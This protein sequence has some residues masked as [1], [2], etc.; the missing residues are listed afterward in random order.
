[1]TIV[2]ALLSV[3]SCFYDGDQWVL[4]R[5][6]DLECF[7]GE[8]WGYSVTGFLLFFLY[9]PVATVVFPNLMYQ[10]KALDLKYDTTFLVVESQGK[11]LIA[12]ASVFFVKELFI[13]LH[14]MVA[15]SICVGLGFY[16]WYSQPC[17]VVP[18]NYWVQWSYLFPIW[19]CV[20]ALIN[21]YSTYKALAFYL[22]VVGL[23]LILI[24][25]LICY[26]ALGKKATIHRSTK[27]DN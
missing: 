1:M 13:W 4:A 16:A 20:C 25:L 18:Y 23:P 26:F 5:K 10:N 21:Y 12:G 7:A 9:Y 14:L 19:A 27:I 2:T 17:L 24:V 22:V 6:H 3:F 8:Y 15:I 11:L